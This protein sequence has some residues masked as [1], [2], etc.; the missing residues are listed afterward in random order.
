MEVLF[1]IPGLA[2]F[3]LP[4]AL[5][6]SL[7]FSRARIYRVYTVYAVVAIFHSFITHNLKRESHQLVVCLIGCNGSSRYSEW[8][9]F[10]RHTILN[11]LFKLHPCNFNKI[12]E[13]SRKQSHKGTKSDAVEKNSK[14]DIQ[15]IVIVSQMSAD[16][17]SYM[18]VLHNV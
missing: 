14:Y 9:R 16:Q 1:K 4:V 18:K 11:Q 13:V 6:M 12:K 8:T 5:F 7:F 10:V 15:I 2:R 17:V 3:L